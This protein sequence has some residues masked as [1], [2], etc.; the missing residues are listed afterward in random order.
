MDSA[1]GNISRAVA[2]ARVAS[3]LTQADLAA[4][5]GTPRRYILELE[6][7]KHPMY[8]RRL[9]TVLDVLG[10]ELVVQPRTT[11]LALDDDGKAG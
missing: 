5:A 7:G 11:R 2:R 9:F 8:L 3:G 1:H 10:L 4:L 6:Q